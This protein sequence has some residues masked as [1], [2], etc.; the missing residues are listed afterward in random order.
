MP[1][2]DGQLDA[3]QEQQKAAVAALSARLEGGDG[4]YDDPLAL[5][6]YLRARP[7]VDG[8]RSRAAF[9]AYGRNWDLDRAE[10]MI[11]GTGAWRKDFGYAKIFTEGAEEIAR[12]AR[13]GSIYVRGYATWTKQKQNMVHLSRRAGVV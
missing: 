7:K 9:R 4:L 1:L 8:C 10:A 11:R 5:V 6:R 3:L 13:V 2:G 12:E